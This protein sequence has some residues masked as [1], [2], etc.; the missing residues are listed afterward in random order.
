M[1]MNTGRKIKV[2]HSDN[3]GKYTSDP[4]L[5]DEG[6]ERHFTVR[7]ISQQNGCRKDEQDLNGEGSLHVIQCRIIEIFLG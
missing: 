4:F 5:G 7:E 3:G 1:E 6:V 2:L